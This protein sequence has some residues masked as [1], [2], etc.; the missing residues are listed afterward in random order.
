MSEQDQAEP[1]TR[2]SLAESVFDFA[3]AY[4]RWRR[5]PDPLNEQWM[6]DAA[7]VA[8]G[9]LGL[10]SVRIPPFSDDESE[11]VAMTPIQRRQD[12]Y[13]R[14]RQNPARIN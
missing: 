13:L 12:A 11:P 10:I 6:R 8:S 3:D 2:D 9:R 4:R 7:K 5:Y 14:G 1:V